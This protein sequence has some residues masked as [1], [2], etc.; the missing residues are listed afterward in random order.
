VQVC[1]SSTQLEL[2][3]YR[4]RGL[5]HSS[6]ANSVADALPATAK[7]F[8]RCS[9]TQLSMPAAISPKAFG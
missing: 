3:L 4:Y 9:C 1:I 2:W 7:N 5:D 6:P 8:D